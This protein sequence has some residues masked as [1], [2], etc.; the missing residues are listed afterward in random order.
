MAFES[1][2][3]LLKCGGTAGLRGAMG[4]GDVLAFYAGYT[5]FISLLLE[6]MDDMVYGMQNSRLP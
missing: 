4:Y 3:N 5:M 1:E 6:A 2:K